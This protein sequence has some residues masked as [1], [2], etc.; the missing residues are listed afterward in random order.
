MGVY[1][2]E[3]CGVDVAP[4]PERQRGVVDRSEVI[5]D[6]AVDCC[7]DDT[8]EN[9]HHGD[10]PQNEVDDLLG[11]PPGTRLELSKEHFGTVHRSRV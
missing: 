6:G 9:C 4:V 2:V 11:C 3:I 10:R 5:G 8:I 7:D 1:G